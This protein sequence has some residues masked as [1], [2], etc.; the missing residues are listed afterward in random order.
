M[1]TILTIAQIVIS[2]LLGGAI[3]LQQRGGGLSPVLGGES[4]VYRTRRGVER[5]VFVATIILV[6]LFLAAAFLNI[7]LR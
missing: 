6:V 5:T 7:I 4:S 1:F 2:I 3:L